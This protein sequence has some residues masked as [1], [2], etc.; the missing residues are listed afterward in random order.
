MN[1]QN[2]LFTFEPET[3]IGRVVCAHVE[4]GDRSSLTQIQ[5]EALWHLWPAGT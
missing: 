4:D 1:S 2:H 3:P 5:K